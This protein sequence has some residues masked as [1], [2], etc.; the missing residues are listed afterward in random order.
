MSKEKNQ[1]IAYASAYVADTNQELVQHLTG[2][3]VGE[4]HDV[5][6]A[7]LLAIKWLE[8]H[9]HHLPVLHSLSHPVPSGCP[10]SEILACMYE[11]ANVN[12]M[13]GTNITRCIAV[14]VQRH[15]LSS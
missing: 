14:T 6:D 13:K 5:A 12:R 10:V 11:A 8:V 15:A 4:M 3:P 2:L 7:C 9:Y 1:R